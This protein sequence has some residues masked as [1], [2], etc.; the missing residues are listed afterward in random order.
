MKQFVLL[1]KEN[2]EVVP[3]KDMMEHMEASYRQWMDD[4]IE[5]G[6]Y[7]TG[8]RLDQKR[9][10]VQ[11]DGNIISDG[12]YVEIKEMIGGLIIIRANDLDE[13]IQLA[14]KCPMHAVHNIDVREVTHEYT[15]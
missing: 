14:L 11:P 13:A 9:K 8:S 12:P 3:E 5:A 1:I 10:T 4:L 6:K 7:V 2:V 15:I